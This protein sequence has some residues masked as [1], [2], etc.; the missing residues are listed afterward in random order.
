MK[1]LYV[2][3]LRARVQ[4]VQRVLPAFG[5]RVQRVWYRRVAAMSINAASRRHIKSVRQDATF[6]FEPVKPSA[7]KGSESGGAPRLLFTYT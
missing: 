5:R 2:W 1:S 3:A 4:K 7:Q 6:P